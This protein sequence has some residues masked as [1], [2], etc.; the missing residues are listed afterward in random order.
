MP[1][2]PKERPSGRLGRLLAA[3]RPSRAGPLPVQTGFPTSLADLVVKN[4]G[5]L[6]KQPSPSSKRGKRSAA[7]AAA[8]PTSSVSPSPSTS[9]P[10]AS[11]PPTPPAAAVSPSD[12]PR[13][14]LPP[15][16]HAAAAS[17]G[18]GFASA[19]GFL[20]GAEVVAAVT[21]A[22]FSLFLLESVRSSL[23]PRPRPAA[24]ERRICLDGRGRVSP[25]REVDAETGPPRLSCSDTDRGSEASILSAEEKS[26]GALD[27]SSSSKAK[28]RSWKKK[29]IA[30][31]KKLNK[32]RKSKEADSPGSFRS[33]GDAADASARRGN[34]IAA[35]PSDSRR[36]TANQTEAAVAEEPDSLRG[37]RRSEGIE[38]MV[39][40]PVEI[41]DAQSV[42]L[43]VEEEEEE[44]GRAGSRFPAGLVL[45]AVVLVG[46]V[47]GKLPAVALTVLC[48]AF[49]SSVQGLPRGG[50]SPPGRRLEEAASSLSS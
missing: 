38:E 4:H 44:E 12:R 49:L 29:L 17:R 43:V 1:S 41:D 15:A 26:G 24:T 33:D 7:A 13:P 42:V 39:A 31:A 35:D 11:P 30:S 37:S 27:E 22:S 14:D 18:G 32:G 50:G 19:W 20:A 3:L 34:A 16:P 36:G 40:A 45:V 47:A 28:K 5:R 6:K 25:I 8:S 9:P 2:P 21:A 48:Y 10:P 46:L 23:R